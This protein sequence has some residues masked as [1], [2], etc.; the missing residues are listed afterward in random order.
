MRLGGWDCEL[1]EGTLSYKAYGKKTIRERH[2]H[3]YEFN[4]DFREQLTKAG[5]VIAG[6][7]PDNSLVEI[8]ELKP[9]DHPWFV[10]V[11]SHPE[12]NSRPLGGHPHF[13]AFIAAAAKFKK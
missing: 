5:L 2:R 8:I 1:M 6:T 9:T 12:F 4:N 13:N 11:Q 10:G 3:R 7:T